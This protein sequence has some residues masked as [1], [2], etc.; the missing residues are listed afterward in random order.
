MKF[1]TRNK[2]DTNF[3]MSSLTDIIFLLLM[4]LLLS[5][6]PY[7]TNILNLS[8]PKSK[9]QQLTGKPLNI[10][11]DQSMNYFVNSKKVSLAELRTRMSALAT[12]NPKATV[13]L[14]AEKS[15]P[16]EAVVSVVAMANE[17]KLS[18]VLATDA[19]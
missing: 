16:I 11:I 15:V 2:V 14:N 1:K 17:F 10:S 19:K 13:V 6:N 5:F 9:G 18:P 7:S 3:S 4:F 8:L 12:E